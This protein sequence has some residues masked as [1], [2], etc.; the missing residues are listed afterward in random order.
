MRWLRHYV[1][2]IIYYYRL[3]YN[4]LYENRNE[5]ENEHISHPNPD[6][7]TYEELLELE[8]KIGYVSK[9]LPQ[10]KIDVNTIILIIIRKFLWLNT[11]AILT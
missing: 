10:D 7:M 5:R 6:T 9:G 4:Y 2:K 3:V 1:I 11:K 8:N